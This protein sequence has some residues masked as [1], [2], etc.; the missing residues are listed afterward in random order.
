MKNI[1]AKINDAVEDTIREDLRNEALEILSLGT[2]ADRRDFMT[3]Y[4]DDKGNVC[5]LILDYAKKG[6]VKR[7]ILEQ[8]DTD[9]FGKFPFEDGE[10]REDLY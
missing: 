3:A 2:K 8:K 1:T 5:C 9:E 10:D 4:N 7:G 6:L